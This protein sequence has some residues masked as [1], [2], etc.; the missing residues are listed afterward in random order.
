MYPRIL[1]YIW[2]YFNLLFTRIEPATVPIGCMKGEVTNSSRC[3]YSRYVLPGFPTRETWRRNENTPEVFYGRA[4]HYEPGMMWATAIS[5]GFDREYLVQFDCLVSGFFIN[6]VGRV[7]WLMYRGMEYQCLVVDN[8]RARDLYETVV[9]NRESVE[10][11]FD[12]ARDVLKDNVSHNGHRIV[13]VAYQIERPTPNEWI[14]AE[15]LDEYLFNTWETSYREPTG[16]I[17][18]KPDQQAYYKIEGYG[19]LWH[20]TPGCLY[21]EDDLHWAFVPNEFEV[22]EVVAGDSLAMI[23]KKMYGYSHPRFWEAIYQANRDQ[24]INPYFVKVGQYLMI[25][26]YTKIEGPPQ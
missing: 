18:V 15:R 23:A 22:Y 4:V 5:R 19:Q 25:P 7:A 16:W 11:E 13:L 1:M 9:F 21:C 17:Q 14:T 6:D 26:L 24:M 12:F 20:R 3:S 10:V 8:A 2:L